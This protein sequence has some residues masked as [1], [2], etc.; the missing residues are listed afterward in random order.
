[1]SL[2]SFVVIA[3]LFLSE[4]YSYLNVE[5]VEELFVDSTAVDQ[6]VDIHFDVTFDHLPCALLSIDVMDISGLNSHDVKG[7]KAIK[8]CI[9]F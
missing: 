9:S 3:L 7:K 4:L 8:V 2:A 6:R 1:M 5:I